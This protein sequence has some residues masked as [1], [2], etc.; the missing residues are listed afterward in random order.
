MLR[1]RQSRSEITG[2]WEDRHRPDCLRGGGGSRASQRPPRQLPRP[3][4]WRGAGLSQHGTVTAELAPLPAQLVAGV[5]AIT[6][7]GV[8]TGFTGTS[9]EPAVVRRP[10]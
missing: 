2:A 9:L 6:P 10:R 4:L 5:V 7:A 8:G 3:P 1:Q